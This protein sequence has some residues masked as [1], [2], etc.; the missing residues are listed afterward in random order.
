MQGGLAARLP[1]GELKSRGAVMRTVI[2]MYE[3]NGEYPSIRDI[4][5]EGEISTEIVHRR[6][7]DLERDGFIRRHSKGRYI[8]WADKEGV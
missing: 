6:L 7:G 3:R 4:A 5:A 2:R 8:I 1:G